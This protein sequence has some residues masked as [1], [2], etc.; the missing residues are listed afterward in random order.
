MTIVI[1]N[2]DENYD[3][4]HHS[5]EQYQS[6]SIAVFLFSFS[7]FYQLSNNRMPNKEKKGYLFW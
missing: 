5:Q 7:F 1:T 4:L 6:E 2:Q 3:M